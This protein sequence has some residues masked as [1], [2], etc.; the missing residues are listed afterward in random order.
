MGSTVRMRSPGGSSL[1]GGCGMLPQRRSPAWDDL[2]VQ[3]PT[4]KVIGLHGDVPPGTPVFDIAM[5]PDAIA[6]ALAQLVRDRWAAEMRG[7]DEGRGS[8]RV[9]VTK[10]C[11]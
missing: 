4:L 6:L 1:A 2:A 7:Y 5:V 8:L 11:R 3:R 10:Q 9:L